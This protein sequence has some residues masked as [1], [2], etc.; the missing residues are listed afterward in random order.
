MSCVWVYMQKWRYAIGK[1]LFLLTKKARE[2]SKKRSNIVQFGRWRDSFRLA[3]C[4][5]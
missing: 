1:L 3:L 5:I 4:S 2:K